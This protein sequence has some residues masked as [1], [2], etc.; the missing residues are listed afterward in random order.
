MPVARGRADG[1]PS[2]SLLLAAAAANFAYDLDIFDDA[3]SM[4]LTE[5]YWS[6]A[7]FDQLGERFLSVGSISS[8]SRAFSTLL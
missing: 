7:V 1:D 3:L 5:G 2:A 4:L 8:Y 6:C